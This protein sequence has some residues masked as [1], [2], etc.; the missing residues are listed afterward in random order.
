MSTESTAHALDFIFVRGPGRPLRLFACDC[1]TIDYK[2][3]AGDN[4]R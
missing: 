4:I 1:D 3:R 2:H